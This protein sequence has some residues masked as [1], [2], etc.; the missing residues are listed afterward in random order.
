M[1]RG[2]RGRG[3][4]SAP[5]QNDAPR[6]GCALSSIGAVGYRSRRP[7]GGRGGTPQ[8]APL[9]P[10]GH[11]SLIFIFPKSELLS[12]HVPDQSHDHLNATHQHRP[13]ARPG[14]VE[15]GCQ[16][17]ADGGPSAQ[18]TDGEGDVHGIDRD[19]VRRAVD[20][21]E[22][23]APAA[24]PRTRALAPAATLMEIEDLGQALTSFVPPASEADADDPIEQLRAALDAVMTRAS[25]VAVRLEDEDSVSRSRQAYVA[26]I[27]RLLDYMLM[28]PQSMDA[29]SK[30]AAIALG[31]V[32]HIETSRLAALQI[33]RTVRD[34]KLATAVQSMRQKMAELA[35]RR[36]NVKVETQDRAKARIA[37]A[38]RG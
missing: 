12:P 27:L 11:S 9:P 34:E 38:G 33:G 17:R 15:G 7:P 35:D 13:P 30:Q 24:H 19:V 31:Y 32:R 6:A 20:G 16:A 5:R 8:A 3:C 10:K 28:E 1:Y 23:Q 29:A 2:G 21:V 22:T 26:S 4:P 25:A 18:A 37:K 14:L 36:A